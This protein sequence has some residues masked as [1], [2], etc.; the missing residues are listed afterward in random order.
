MT[1]RGWRAF[2]SFIATIIASCLI[3]S[4]FGWKIGTS[5]GLVVWAIMP[6]TIE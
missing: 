5:I 1:P 4:E 6:E 2:A 3:G